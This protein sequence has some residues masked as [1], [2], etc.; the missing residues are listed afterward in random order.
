VQA[1]ETQSRG[2]QPTVQS[3]PTCVSDPKTTTPDRRADQREQADGR[4]ERCLRAPRLSDEPQE[5][6]PGRLQPDGKHD[7]PDEQGHEH[8]Y[9]MSMQPDGRVG[10]EPGEHPHAGREDQDDRQDS[11]RRDPERRSR[12]R[13]GHPGGREWSHRRPPRSWGHRAAWR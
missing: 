6:V 5:H 13:G 3:A 2:S 11:E 1:R 8:A 4:R 10:T 7:V 12:R 9:E